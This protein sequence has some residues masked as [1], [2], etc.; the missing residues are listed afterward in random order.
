M[1]GRGGWSDGGGVIGGTPD[2]DKRS[3]SV[4]LHMPRVLQALG[5]F[6]FLAGF[7]SLAM[8]AEGG[9]TLFAVV[10][11]GSVSGATVAYVLPWVYSGMGTDP[12]RPVPDE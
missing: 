1:A 8:P 2:N 10:V 6:G 12:V 5:F 4:P 3:A 11:V 9:A 7:V